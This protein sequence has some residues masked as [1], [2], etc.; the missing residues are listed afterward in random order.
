V[1]ALEGLMSA[2]GWVRIA[3]KQPRGKQDR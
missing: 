3:G 1:R 2:K